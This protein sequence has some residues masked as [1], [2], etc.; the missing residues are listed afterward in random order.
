MAVLPEVQSKWAGFSSFGD[1][2]VFHN[3]YARHF[4]LKLLAE[5]VFSQSKVVPLFN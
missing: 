2:C 3:S 4:N 1:L 5:A